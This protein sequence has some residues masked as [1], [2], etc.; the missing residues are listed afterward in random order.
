[1][2]AFLLY[3]DH[4]F[5]PKSGLPWNEL[6]L[7]QD[8]ELET[9]L[10]AMSGE[11]EFLYGVARAALLKGCE[12]PE[13]VLYRQA[14][15]Q[16]VLANP[17]ILRSLYDLVVAALEE[18]RKH[19]W[20][21][22]H[23]P[24]GILHHS[25]DALLRLSAVLR[26][27]REAADTQAARF[28]SEGF[29]RL[30]AMLQKELDDAYFDTIRAHLK[31]LKFRHGTLISARLGIGN[32]GI[33]YVLRTPPEHPHNWLT[34]LFEKKVPSYSFTLSPRDENGARALSELND[35]GVNLVANALAQSMEHIQSFLAMMRQEL[36]FYLCGLNL[37]ERLVQKGAPTAFPHPARVGERVLTCRGL[38]DIC[39]ALSMPQ[40]V[41]GNDLN[42]DGKNLFIVTGANQGGKSTFLRSVGLAQL[43]MAC[44]LFVPAESYA[45][46]L[47]HGLYTHYKREEDTT[48]NSGKLD[49][50]MA[51]MSA[52]MDH[53][54]PDSLILFNE[55]F[56]ATNEREGSQIA[57]QITRALRAHHIKIVAVS[58][59]YE[60]ARAL[61][62]DH[63]PDALFL[64][65]HR[66]EDGTR[67]FRL[68]EAPPLATS[69][70][71]DLYEKIFGTRVPA[72][73]G[74]PAPD[75]AP[76]AEAAIP[77]ARSS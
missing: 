51:R 5:D 12:D 68:E 47:C 6:D 48:M 77:Q 9:L 65:A 45:A 57:G 63:L 17:D 55:S 56:A 62:D 18:E 71:A 43:M 72:A 8:L 24:A 10:R 31:A 27:L 7:V 37:H 42:A 33:D 22:A 46:D 70:G 30:F 49:E 16:D 11:D 64:R 32:H 26:Q 58:H 28:T 39:L 50:E 20:T 61:Y 23:Y 21:L 36:A 34:R 53:L 60:F 74:T 15:L 1:M 2:K 52:I 14:V 13:T 35:R 29:S 73:S 67:T 44:G 54:K 25:V 4:D 59:L 40:R 66:D 41:V 69:Y 3:R 76:V 75:A 38:Y 19:Y